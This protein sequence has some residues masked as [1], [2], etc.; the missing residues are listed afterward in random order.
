MKQ[1]SYFHRAQ[2]RSSFLITNLSQ[3]PEWDG[4]RPVLDSCTALCLT[5]LPSSPT[6]LPGTLLH[7]HP[8]LR[9]HP[10]ATA[11]TQQGEVGVGWVPARQW[12]P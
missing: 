9:V 6:A 2:V 3:L 7:T 4:L 1:S 11:E 10:L 12:E 5:L 8:H